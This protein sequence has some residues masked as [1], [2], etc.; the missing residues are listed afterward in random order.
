VNQRKRQADR[1]ASEADWRTLVRCAKNDNQE[2][3]CHHDF[4]DETGHH[5]VAA[6]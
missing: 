3:E 5:R 2:H 6:G 4:G 1:Q